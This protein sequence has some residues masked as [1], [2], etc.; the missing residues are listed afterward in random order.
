MRRCGDAKRTKRA[1]ADVDEDDEDDEDD[2]ASDDDD[3]KE[4]DDDDDDEKICCCCCW[5]WNWA[6][7]SDESRAGNAVAAENPKD[8]S[9]L[10]VESRKAK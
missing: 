3:D 7:P 1:D 5:Y 9:S 10:P 2:D 8:R 6:S 4:V